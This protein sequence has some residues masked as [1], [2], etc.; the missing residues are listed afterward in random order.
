MPSEPSRLLNIANHGRGAGIESPACP[1]LVPF[2]DWRVQR[3]PNSG[4]ITKCAM[5][6]NLV[7]LRGYALKNYGVM[8]ARKEGIATATT[9]SDR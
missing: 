4:D 5:T 3:W 1:C 2:F 6:R 7:E 9:K 8:E